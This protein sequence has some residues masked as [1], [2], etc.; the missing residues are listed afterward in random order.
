MGI[1]HFF[2]WFM[3]NFSDHIYKIPKYQTLENVN[4]ETDNLMVDLNGAFHTSTQKIHKYGN[5]KPRRRLI[6]NKST[7]RHSGDKLA[8]QLKV[9][10]DVCKTIEKIFLIVKPKKRLILCVDGPAP[11]SKQNQQRQRRFRSAKEASGN[12]TTTFDSNCITP[13]TKFMDYLSKYIDWYIRK[14]ISEDPA[15]QQIEIVFSNEKAPGEGEHKIINYIRFYGKKEETYCIN[16]LDADLI[17]LALGT[18]MPNFYILREDLYDYNNEYFCINIGKVYINLYEKLRWSCEK[19]SFNP[20]YAINDFIFLCFIVGNDFLPHIPSIEIIE[21]GLEL[22]LE[23]YKEVGSSY[24][25]ITNEHSGRVQFVPVSLGVFLGTIGQHEQTNFENKLNSKKSFFPDLLLESCAT[26]NNKGK[27]DVD[28]DKYKIKYINIL[29]PEN[30]NIKQICHEYLEGMQWVLSYYTRGVPNWK[31]YFAYHYSPPAS[32]LS[33]YM[34]SFKF[35]IYGR[36]IPST[37]FQQLLSVLPPKSANLIPF[38]LN[39]LL[40][41][42]TSPLKKH[43]PDDFEIDLSGK[44]KE[45]EGIV[46]LPMVDFNLVRECYFNKL[47]LV[48]PRELKRNIKGRSVVYQYISE[49]PI[50]FKS[51]YG[52]ILKCFVKTN[53]IDL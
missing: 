4:V 22:I 26:Q 21:H 11:I 14:K 51:Y 17:M 12:P 10:E 18:H 41:D 13:G 33:K 16:G 38:P 35:P 47:H 52:N 36:T 24:G 39:N 31:W 40:T 5:F 8:T 34:K 2:H 27:W 3:K 1:K 6:K 42:E 53:L 50:I 43:C 19:Y 45:W 29:F 32:I 20:K 25:H 48:N 9:F 37:P 44:R 15:W 30:S 46:I 28:I 49:F 7:K 23:V